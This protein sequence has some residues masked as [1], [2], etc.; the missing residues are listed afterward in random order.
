MCFISYCG[1][2]NHPPLL[3]YGETAHLPGVRIESSL[4]SA[5]LRPC[6]SWARHQQ[7][8]RWS[9]HAA[10]PRTPWCGWQSQRW[11]G[12]TVTRAGGSQKPSCRQLWRHQSLEAAWHSPL[13]VC[14]SAGTSG[15]SSPERWGAL[16]LPAAAAV[17]I[18]CRGTTDE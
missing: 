18:R 7:R 12:A 9:R 13:G 5:D 11:C 2:L 17:N 8:V 16:W 3:R 15:Q 4:A 1:H 10:L 6:A 14:V